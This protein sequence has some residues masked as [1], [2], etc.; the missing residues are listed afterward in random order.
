MR[1]TRQVV[2]IREEV[3]EHEDSVDGN[4]RGLRASD[5]EI[6]DSLWKSDSDVPMIWKI[7]EIIND[8]T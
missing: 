7:V 3:F 5:F 6:D 8:R 2:G 4:A 1:K